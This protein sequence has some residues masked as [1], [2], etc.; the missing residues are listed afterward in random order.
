MVNNYTFYRT[1]R[2]QDKNRENAVK[3]TPLITGLDVTALLKI[4]LLEG[5]LIILGR[6]LPIV[7]KD[8]AMHT[9]YACTLPER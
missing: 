8:C 6:R 5:R 4:I 1:V 9:L 2:K 7:Y 3:Y